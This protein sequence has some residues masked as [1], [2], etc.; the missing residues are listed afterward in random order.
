MNDLP[1]T[2]IKIIV[3]GDVNVGKTSLLNRYCYNRFDNFIK[4]T[5]GCDFST[6][7]LNNING[8]I[9]RLQL[10]DIAGKSIIYIFINI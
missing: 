8:K 5:I 6:K 3:V 1:I 9:I 4:P 10:W 2:F 7:I